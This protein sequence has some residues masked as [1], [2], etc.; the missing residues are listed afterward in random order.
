MVESRRVS[1]TKEVLP[2]KTFAIDATGVVAGSS[3]SSPEGCYARAF[4]GEQ[5]QTPV[6]RPGTCYIG[7]Y[8]AP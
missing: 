6:G 8:Y 3:L 2:W 5:G 7:D 4:S 1:L